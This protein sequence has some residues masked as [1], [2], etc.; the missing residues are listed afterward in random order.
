[1]RGDS[2]SDGTWEATI[3]PGSDAEGSDRQCDNQGKAGMKREVTLTVSCDCGFWIERVFYT[4][5]YGYFEISAAYC[6]DCLNILT[7]I[8]QQLP[9]DAIPI[10][11]A[12]NGSE[13]QTE[14]ID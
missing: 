10:G 9:M 12:E 8:A 7:W 5:E 13:T 1:M 4:N 11:S 2:G 6:P 14:S 3:S